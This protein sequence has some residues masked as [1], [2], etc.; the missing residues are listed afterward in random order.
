MTNRTKINAKSKLEKV[1]P[2]W[3]QYY[4]KC[5]QNRAQIDAQIN[6]K[7]HAKNQSNKYYEIFEKIVGRSGKISKNSAPGLKKG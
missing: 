2:K 7:T 1:M 5:V 3:C 6:E 4:R